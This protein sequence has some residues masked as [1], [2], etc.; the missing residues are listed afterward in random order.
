MAKNRSKYESYRQR[1]IAEDPY[2]YRCGVEH[3]D[4]P[5]HYHHKIP[6]HTGETDHSHG[7]LLC[8]RCHCIV[9]A[10]ERRQHKV[11]DEDGY[12]H[13]TFAGQP[14]RRREQRRSRAERLTEAWT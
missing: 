1:L 12:T 2:C 9:H 8:R 6:Q 5:L 13:S 4:E 7:V 11:V 3:G 10:L 14:R